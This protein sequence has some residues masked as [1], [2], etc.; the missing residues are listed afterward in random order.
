MLSQLCIRLE[1]G[2]WNTQLKL[3]NPHLLHEECVKLSQKIMIL[4]FG[5]TLVPAV[6]LGWSS[7]VSVDLQRIAGS[8]CRAAARP[9]AMLG[10]FCWLVCQKNSLYFFNLPQ[11]VLCFPGNASP[12]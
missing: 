10:L 4:T 1:A 3:L 7:A 12:L 11:K 6:A 8:A 2:T 9:P 5:S